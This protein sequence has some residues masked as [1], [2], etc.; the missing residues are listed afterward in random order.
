M[1]IT[2]FTATDLFGSGSIPERSPGHT[3]LSFLKSGDE[4]LI[5]SNHPQNQK[6]RELGC[7]VILVPRIPFEKGS[8]LLRLFN[9]C[10]LFPIQASIIGIYQSL[11]K[12][13]SLLYLYEVHGVLAGFWVS[14]FLGTRRLHRFQGTVLQPILTLSWISRLAL[15]FRKLDHGLALSLPAPLTVMT[16]DG[17]Q[18]DEV[19]NKL[20]LKNSG[21]ILFWRNGLASL[22]STLPAGTMR[23]RWGISEKD[24]VMIT[25]SRLEKWKRVERAIEVMAELKKFNQRNAITKNF[26]LVICGDGELR[27][28]LKALVKKSQLEK[29]IIFSGSV[30][31]PELGNYYQDA[32]IFLSFYDLSNLGNPIME[33]MKSGKFI[34]TLKSG[35]TERLISHNTNGLVFASF[36]ANEIAESIYRLAENPGN[37]Q[38]FSGAIKNSAEKLLWDWPTRLVAER[39]AILEL[40]KNNRQ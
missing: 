36:N 23:R 39:S 24:I 6:Y 16:D 19:L 1:K 18:G 3:L 30:P 28:S 11:K 34:I 12:R 8:R 10:V 17:T 21:K 7:R 2:I 13:P 27:D 22:N 14:V 15:L 4:I 37:I 25:V 26:Y 32:D 31:Q 20:R 29:L 35:G 40:I 9:N 5:I 38:K 33:A